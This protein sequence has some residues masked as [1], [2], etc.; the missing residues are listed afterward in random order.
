MTRTNNKNTFFTTEE[1]KNHTHTH[2]STYPIKSR[3]PHP[4]TLNAKPPGQFTVS[5]FFPDKR[6]GKE[7]D[8]SKEDNKKN[9]E[10][11]T[12]QRDKKKG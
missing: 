8:K 7:M 2:K 1:I 10:K 4:P 12:K 6:R 3:T 5:M 9:I 11:R